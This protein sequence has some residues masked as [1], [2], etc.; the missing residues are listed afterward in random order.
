[1]NSMYTFLLRA[2]N[3]LLNMLGVLLTAWALVLLL[4]WVGLTHG[5]WVDGMVAFLQAGVGW[6]LAVVILTLA[7]CMWCCWPRKKRRRPTRY[8]GGG[9]S[10]GN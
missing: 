8:R 5:A 4:G 9:L 1:L 3:I 6:G 7:A 10:R 2:R